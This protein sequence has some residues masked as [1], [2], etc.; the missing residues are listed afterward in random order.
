MSDKE[1]EVQRRERPKGK[2]ETEIEWDTGGRLRK[3]GWRR[4]ERGQKV[5]K[6]D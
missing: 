4:M 5:T 2:G 6:G 1:E 3:R